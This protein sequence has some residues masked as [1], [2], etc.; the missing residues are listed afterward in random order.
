MYGIFICITIGM[1]IVEKECMPLEEI[2]YTG[3]KAS[4][5]TIALAGLTV[6]LVSLTRGIGFYFPMA[7]IS[8]GISLEFSRAFYSIG[9]ILAGIVGDRSR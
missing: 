5:G 4:I 1:I 6:V 3:E 9:L 8:K 7:D 2:T